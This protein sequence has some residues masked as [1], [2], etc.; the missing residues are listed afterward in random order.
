MEAT[1]AR[2]VGLDLEGLVGPYGV[3]VAEGVVIFFLWRLF[4]EEQR[5]SR[6]LT[7]AVRELTAEVRSWRTTRGD[8]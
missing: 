5:E 7:E 1:H 2:T 3:V 8:K 4:R 6:S